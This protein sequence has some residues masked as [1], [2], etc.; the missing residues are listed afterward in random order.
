M[1]LFTISDL[2]LSLSIDKPMDVFGSEWDHYMERLFENWS[3]TVSSTDTVIVGGDVSWAMYLNECERDFAFLNALPGTKIILKGN[4]DYW[5][6]SLTKLQNYVTEK[7][8][9]TLC[10]LHNN[11]YLAEDCAICG[12][13]GWVDPSYES[14]KADDQKI[15][16]RELARMELSLK[17]AAK[18][19]AKKIIAVL[20]YPPI[21]KTLTVSE[22][23]AALFQAYGVSLCVYGHLHARA[24]KRAFE[25]MAGGVEYKLAAADYM[26]FTP[27]K[28]T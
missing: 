1:S 6:E 11:A 12:T 21:T 4:H 2:H 10:F 17:S 3:S 9:S 18:L 19:G 8:F 24:S 27:Y 13:R 5:W 14:F 25:G 28:L 23:Y 15:Y 20:H 7:G 16:L 22:Q 26:G